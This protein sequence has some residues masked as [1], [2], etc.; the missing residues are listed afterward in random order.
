MTTRPSLTPRQRQV[1]D[2]Y[3]RGRSGYAIAHELG[4]TSARVYQI[5]ARLRQLGVIA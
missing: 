4:I 5:L 2:L 3:R 1:R